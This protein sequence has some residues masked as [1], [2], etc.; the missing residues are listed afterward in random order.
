MQLER[1]YDAVDTQHP[2]AREQKEADEQ[3]SACAAVST[4]V[5]VFFVIALVVSYISRGYQ[6]ATA[7]S[8]SYSKATQTAPKRA[9]PPQSPT[10]AHT[11]ASLIRLPLS[12]PLTPH[13]I[14]GGLLRP[15]ALQP[16]R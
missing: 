11:F 7:L 9:K 13:V 15:C 16:L 3:L 14:E 5:L 1:R 10:Q 8:K 2:R 12:D 6:V 4:C